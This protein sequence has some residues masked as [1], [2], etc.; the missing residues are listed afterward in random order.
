MPASPSLKKLDAKQ[1][2]R[3]AR[4]LAK[5]LLD[6]SA[7]F[8]TPDSEADSECTVAPQDMKRWIGLAGKV[9]GK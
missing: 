6:W 4:S 9:V 3:A 1:R 7:Q 2:Q 5:D 8:G